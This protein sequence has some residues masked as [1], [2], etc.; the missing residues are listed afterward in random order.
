MKYAAD[1]LILAALVLLALGLGILFGPAV[2]CFVG[3]GGC[4]A[5]GVWIGIRGGDA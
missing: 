4:V 2:G 5:L 3:A 1:V